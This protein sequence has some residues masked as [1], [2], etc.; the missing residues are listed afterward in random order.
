M[1]ITPLERVFCL[2]LTLTSFFM[3]YFFFPSALGGLK[4]ISG[5]VFGHT[6]S[7]ESFLNNIC[8]G[9]K[10][11]LF[12]QGSRVFVK[13]DQILKSAF[14][15]VLCP[16]VSPRVEKI[17]WESFLR[18]SNAL[19]KNFLFNSHPDV[20]CYGLFLCPLSLGRTKKCFRRRFRTH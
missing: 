12:S 8:W 15:A 20:I 5:D 19:T 7:F 16:Y 3:G 18:A 10:H 14:F 13:I 6:D 11:R 1:Q 17:P 9:S 2:T 4:R